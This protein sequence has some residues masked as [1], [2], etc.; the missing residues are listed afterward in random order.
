MRFYYCSIFGTND[1]IKNVLWVLSWL[2]LRNEKMVTSAKF[3]ATSHFGAA[4]PRKRGMKLQGNGMWGDSQPS[5]CLDRGDAPEA[6][7]RFY[8]RVTDSTSSNH[9][10][11]LQTARQW[12]CLLGKGVEPIF[13]FCTLGGAVVQSAPLKCSPSEATIFLYLWCFI[14]LRK[15]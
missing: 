3:T 13:S 8:H 5:R 4:F 14:T 1:Q 6:H 9:H 7:W 11:V 2:N 15:R 10:T 12:Y